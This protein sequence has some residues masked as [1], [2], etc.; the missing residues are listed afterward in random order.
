MITP[1]LHLETLFVFNQKRRILFTREPAA[2]RGPLFSLVRSAR[3]CAWAFRADVPDK[4]AD[5]IDNLVRQEPTATDLR[6]TPVHADR[7]MSILS[8]VYTQS[9]ATLRQSSGPAFTFPETIDA[10]DDVI[11]VEDEQLLAKTFRG[12]SPG[13]IAA[14]CGPMLAVFQNGFP[15]S[16]CFSARSSNRAAEAGVE[17]AEEFRRHGFATRVTAAWALAVRASGRIPLYS[18]CW[19]NRASLSVARKLGLVTYASD[20]TIT[21]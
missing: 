14:G 6:D 15:V 7:Y 11:I 9:G 2:L 1:E 20:W 12:W 8:G 3:G 5:E 13:E 19:T 10:T 18:T 16:I 21:D 4:A 17:T